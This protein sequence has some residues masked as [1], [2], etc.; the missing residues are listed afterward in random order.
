LFVAAASGD[1]YSALLWYQSPKIWVCVSVVCFCVGVSGSIFCVIKQA[2]PYG[3]GRSGLVLFAPQGRD[4]YFIEGIVVALWTIG[5]A[6]SY[7]LMNYA[8]RLRFPVLRH[9]LVLLSMTLFIVLSLQ[10]WNA[11]IDKTGWY[12]LRETLPVEVWSYLSGSVKKSSG[13]PKRLLR[14]SEY[15]LFETKD[16]EGFVKKFNTLVVDYMKREFLGL[17]T[18]AVDK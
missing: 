7:A 17:A 4:Q 13:L 1:V 12:S 2:Q 18:G 16:W 9:L 15:W 10:I 11:Y 14:M 6:L 5:A 3:M 8:T